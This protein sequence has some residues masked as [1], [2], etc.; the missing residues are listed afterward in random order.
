M[1]DINAA[2]G[3]PEI[4]GVIALAAGRQRM[5]VDRFVFIFDAVLIEPICDLQLFIAFDLIALQG[6]QVELFDI[7]IPV[8]LALKILLFLRFDKEVGEP[9]NDCAGNIGG[10]A[11]QVLQDIA[12]QRDERGIVCRVC[13]EAGFDPS[14]SP[15]MS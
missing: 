6:A 9:G 3:Q 1:L 15:M 5:L 14:T 12:D 8:V 13:G 2:F 10:R 4:R 11:D 7:S